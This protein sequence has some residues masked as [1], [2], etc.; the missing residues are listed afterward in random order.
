MQ[1]RP[2]CSSY[3]SPAY[4][5]SVGRVRLVTLVGVCR[6]LSSVTLAHATSLI[7]GQHAAGQSCYVPLG[8]TPIVF[9]ASSIYFHTNVQP[10]LN[11]IL[12][13]HFQ[14]IYG[15][16]ATVPY[17]RSNRGTCNSSCTR[18]R[19]VTHAGNRGPCCVQS[20][21]WIRF[22]LLLHRHRRRTIAVRQLGRRDQ[23]DVDIVC[24]CCR[25]VRTFDLAITHVSFLIRSEVRYRWKR[26]RSP[27][28][29]WRTAPRKRCPPDSRRV[30]YN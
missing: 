6:R 3:Y 10:F 14:L 30:F 23:T 27:A 22:S 29:R 4:I 5:H 7:M 9:T 17:C 1:P 11:Q 12:H 25:P 2:R 28:G 13:K 8:A 26:C 19:C 21:R 18:G 15:R 24:Y 20:G 16:G